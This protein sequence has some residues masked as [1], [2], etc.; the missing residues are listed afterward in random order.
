MTSNTSNLIRYIDFLHLA[1]YIDLLGP[2]TSIH[3]HIRDI[4]VKDRKCLT[5]ALLRRFL[6]AEPAADIQTILVEALAR[7]YITWLLTSTEGQPFVFLGDTDEFEGFA[8]EL[9][10]VCGRVMGAKRLGAKGKL[11]VVDPLSGKDFTIALAA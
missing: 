1:D 10:R 8:A 4:L 5:P 7:F 6:L 9:L 2:F 3:G 11:M